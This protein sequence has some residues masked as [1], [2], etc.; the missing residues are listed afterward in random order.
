MSLDQDALALAQR[1]M[2]TETFEYNEKHCAAF[3]QGVRLTDEE[4]ANLVRDQLVYFGYLVCDPTCKSVHKTRGRVYNLSE[5]FYKE[6]GDVV[7][8]QPAV[9]GYEPDEQSTGEYEDPPVMTDIRD[10]EE[11]E[12]ELAKK[13]VEVVR[14][15]P[16]VG[17]VIL[18]GGGD[19]RV[20]VTNE[21]DH[22]DTMMNLP[23]PD[24]ILVDVLSN[25]QVARD[26]SIQEAQVVNEEPPVA[27]APLV[28]PDMPV[29]PPPFPKIPGSEVEDLH[30]DGKA[31][32]SPEAGGYFPNAEL[33]VEDKE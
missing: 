26:A 25:A 4:S 11:G 14:R 27:R 6:Y 20:I 28:E 3:L 24:I 31:K 13:L 9:A 29:D 8:D 30:A 32:K 17:T 2:V 33:P 12:L 16:D 23:D 22:V 7:L 21:A 15:N 1:I 18:D 10:L 19:W 5:M